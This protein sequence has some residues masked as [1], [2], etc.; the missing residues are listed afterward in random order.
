MR[1]RELISKHLKCAGTVHIDDLKDL[2]VLLVNK[3]VNQEPIAA[4]NDRYFFVVAH[5][6]HWW[7]VMDKIAKNLHARGL[8]TE[9]IPKIWPNYDIAAESLG[10][11][12]KFIVPMCM[13][14]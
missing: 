14:K 1:Y 13:T 6:E 12:R 7:K 2:Y 8:V 9:P 3:I 4:D 5:R 10:F 11:P